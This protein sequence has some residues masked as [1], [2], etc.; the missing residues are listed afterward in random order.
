MG[1][2]GLTFTGAVAA[3][4]RH[5]LVPAPKGW[6]EVELCWAPPLSDP[7]P[8]SFFGVDE[9][10][11]ALVSGGHAV[12]D[13][14]RRIARFCKADPP[15]GHQ[16]AHPC[17]STAS[18]YFARWDARLS[19]HASVVVLHGAAW[20]VLGSKE[21]GKSTTVAWLAQAGY[22]VLSDDLLVLDGPMALAGPR[23]IDLRLPSA[24]R[25][26]REGLVVVRK[27]ERHRLLLPGVAAEV[28]FGGFLVLTAGHE[29]SVER[30]PL[31]DR[32]EILRHHLTLRQVG[33]PAVALLELVSLPMWRVQRSS[34]WEHL[35][36]LL[37]RLVATVST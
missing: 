9:A 6:P 30:T 29:V 3:L 26:G 11:L 22:D 12:L 1:A 13:R 33:A 20:G 15:D 14:P 4:A 8:A 23:I 5:V 32:L 18:S 17:L 25:I 37:E 27:G 10:V 31:A 34:D 2:Y 7:P 28:P 19:F 24:E 36:M 16:V 21:A 35:P